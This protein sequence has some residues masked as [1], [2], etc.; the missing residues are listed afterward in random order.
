VKLIPYRVRPEDH[1]SLLERVRQIYNE[2]LFDLATHASKFVTA[3]AQLT[4]WRGLDHEKVKLWVF[5]PVNEPWEIVAFCK[6]T[7]RGD[8]VTP[9]F[10]ID[11]AWWGR[12]FG[13][14]IIDYYI[15]MA[16]KPLYGE[17]L[18]TN[19]PIRHMNQKAGWK[20]I[21]KEEGVEYLYHPGSQWTVHH[22]N[23]MSSTRQQEIYDEIIRYHEEP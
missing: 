3:D 14:E 21:E 6:L 22:L 5:S 15:L 23:R 13:T 17:Q 7:D 8:F 9:Q 11:A 4:W 18:S 2:N 16:G 12:G 19:L 20:L 10:A 1:P